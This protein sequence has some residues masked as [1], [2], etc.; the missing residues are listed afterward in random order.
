M[1]GKRGIESPKQG[2]AEGVS[3]EKAARVASLDERIAELVSVY[4][5]S[6]IDTIADDAGILSQTAEDIR[7][8]LEAKGI[9]LSIQKDE[10]NSD[11]SAFVESFKAARQ[12]NTGR[13][14][15]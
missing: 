14:E 6:R 13:R 9:S 12:Q 5:Q 11:V 2:N 3:I 10:S 8:A 1:F 4:E 7:K 15:E